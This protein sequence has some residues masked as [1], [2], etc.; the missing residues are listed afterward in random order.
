MGN[1]CQ[2]IPKRDISNHSKTHVNRS[3]ETNERTSTSP[4]QAFDK[5]ELVQSTFVIALPSSIDHSLLINGF[6][7]RYESSIPTDIIHLISEFYPLFQVY[8]IGRHSGEFG[9]GH[10]CTIDY[11]RKYMIRTIHGDLCCV[12]S[13]QCG[14]CGLG[15]A[16]TLSIMNVSILKPE[17]LGYNKVE[18]IS[19]GLCSH[20]TFIVTIDNE[21]WAWGDN[22]HSQL[23]INSRINKITQPQQ[24]MFDFKARV[25]QIASGSNHTIFVTDTGC[26]YGCGEIASA[27]PHN[28]SAPVLIRVA[29]DNESIVRVDCGRNYTLCLGACGNVYGFGDNNKS[30]IDYDTSDTLVLEPLKVQFFDDKYCVKVACGYRHSAVMD[31]D[32]FVYC[33]GNNEY[34]Q[35]GNGNEIHLTAPHK[36]KWMKLNHLIDE[37][38]CD[39]LMLLEQMERNEGKWIE[40]VDV[41][42]GDNHTLIL[43]KDNRVYTFGLNDH[44][45]CSSFCDENC[46]DV[47]Y[48]LQREEIGIP[49]NCF[50]SR[51]IGG[52]ST[53]LIMTH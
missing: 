5:A 14:E 3:I 41:T 6:I 50:I 18:I 8:G 23:G 37:E 13:N 7:N 46:V 29:D 44:Y 16:T 53:T 22:Y 40:A 48:W 49:Q 1:T 43:T 25:I 2:T 21:V 35:I 32:G 42:C 17:Q 9:L 34:G 12:G 36:I 38:N 19:S 4:S 20:S 11:F 47:P 51:V 52:I 27:P 45:Q 30:Q 33:F 26:I 24:V 39:S 10:G 31:S 28:A 15:K